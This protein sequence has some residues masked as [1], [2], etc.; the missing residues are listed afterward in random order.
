V[1][2]SALR[3]RVTRALLDFAWNEWSQMGVLG[4]GRRLSEWAADP[5]AHLLFTFQSAR[6]DPR[7]FDETLDWLATNGHVISAQRLRNM[8]TSPEDER[9]AEAAIASSLRVPRAKRRTSTGEPE[10]LFYGL[11]L[12]RSPDAAFA[13]H[14]FVR[15]SF[16]PSRKSRRPELRRPINFAFRL[17][18]VF[19]VGSRAEVFR[20]LLTAGGRSLSGR[21]PL[22]T[23]LSIADAAGFAKRNVQDA[24]SALADARAVQVVVRGKEHLYSVDRDAW[25]QALELEGG[26]PQYRDWPGALSGFR[27]LHRWLWESDLERMT[28]YMRGSEARVLAD[29]LRTTFTYAGIPVQERRS[30]AGADYWDV[31]VDVVDQL[32][33]QLESGLP[34]S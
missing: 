30:A 25:S 14:G 3:D 27:E 10:P 20:F 34:G 33:A 1:E 6:S 26:P 9:L 31:F 18:S 16:E 2:P 28:P 23:T 15:P 8:A 4:R 11:G 13:E 19:G 24:L 5:E 29:E 32:L 7:L 17:R 12:S 21:R 22:F